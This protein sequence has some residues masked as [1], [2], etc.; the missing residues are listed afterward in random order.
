MRRPIQFAPWPRVTG[1]SL[2]SYLYS[3]PLPSTNRYLSTIEPPRSPFQFSEDDHFS[4]SASE[5]ALRL[6]P[7]GGSA[8]RGVGSSDGTGY[9]QPLLQML[10]LDGIN[11]R[12]VGSRKDGSMPNN[13]HE[14]WRGFR[15]DQIER[16]A[17]KSAAMLSP[18]VF[19]VNAGSND[20][21]Q[22]FNIPE[23]GNRVGGMLDY[24]WLASPQCTILLSTLIPSADKEVD[25]LV[26]RVNDQFRALEQQKA[27]EQK[28]IV[29]VD[30]HA[31]DGPDVQDFA[32]GIHPD[33]KGY[34]RMARLWFLGVQEALQKG[35]ID[36]SKYML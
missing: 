32:D 5:A 26:M 4:A 12:M 2:S 7:L 17:R 15:I 35:F 14:G 6:M 3:L 34:H 29:L 18:N 23:A 31:S 24:L 28:K 11:A 8:T 33:D 13:S 19:L 16:K 36:G 21:L 30:M 22:K 10:R 9:R 20:C 1:R 25:S 27:T